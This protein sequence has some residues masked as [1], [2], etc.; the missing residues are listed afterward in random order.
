VLEHFGLGRYGDPINYNGHLVGLEN[1]HRTLKT[2]G[3]FY[4]AVPIGLPQRI[5]FNA[6]RI[7]SV[8]YLLQ[9]LE[10]KFHID[11]F[12]FVDDAGDLHENVQLTTQDIES[13][14]GVALYGGSACSN[15]WGYGSGIFEMTKL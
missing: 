8:K 5:M 12:S 4:L 3:K 10:G 7:F 9:Q 6:H 2:G 14:F 1:M 11:H 15:G 13:N